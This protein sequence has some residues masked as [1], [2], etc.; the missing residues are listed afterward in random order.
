[1]S[2]GKLLKLKYFQMGLELLLKNW[3]K[4]EMNTISAS[5]YY[6]FLKD[7]S[8]FLTLA[9][10]RRTTNDQFHFDCKP[11]SLKNVFEVIDHLLMVKKDLNYRELHELNLLEKH[12]IE[13]FFLNK[14]SRTLELFDVN[15]L[16]SDN[17]FLCILLNNLHV[18]SCVGSVMHYARIK[19][20]E[21]LNHLSEYTTKLEVDRIKTFFERNDISEYYIGYGPA[22]VF[23]RK[24]RNKK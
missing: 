11:S 13:Q 3:S 16:G 15:F 21:K 7:S 22:L 1:M 6:R 9:V 18:A 19:G 4:E 20:K 23:C 5:Q 12:P 8:I 17:D 10:N 24:L 2:F 14:L